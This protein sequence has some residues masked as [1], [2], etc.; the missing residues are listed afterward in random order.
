M[1][2]EL[3]FKSHVE[4]GL[5]TSTA[6]ADVIVESKVETKRKFDS[7]QKARTAA[8]KLRQEEEKK[9]RDD[10]QAQAKEAMQI[11]R[12]K[13]CGDIQKTGQLARP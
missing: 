1:G 9:E 5:A 4:N 11:Q 2:V 12:L 8:M 13:Q 6:S 3:L 10:R 7:E